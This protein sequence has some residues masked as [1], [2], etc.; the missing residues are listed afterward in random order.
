MAKTFSR[1]RNQGNSLPE[2]GFPIST[3]VA[4]Q[5]MVD[6]WYNPANP[7]YWAVHSAEDLDVKH[8]D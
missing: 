4:N 5:D 2:M 3:E 1:Q 7:M 8:D 6:F